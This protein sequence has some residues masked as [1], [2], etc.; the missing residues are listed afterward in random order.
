MKLIE[1]L[2]S[3]QIALISNGKFDDM[4]LILK[5]AFPRTEGANGAFKYYSI[6]KTIVGNFQGS[7][8]HPNIT[9][10]EAKNF[11]EEMK[12][13][14]PVESLP[15]RK[16]TSTQA[17]SIIDAACSAWKKTLADKW[18]IGIVLDNK[19][20]IE[21][22]FYQEMRKAC[23][24]EQN[25][26]FDIIFDD[27]PQ[28]EVGGYFTVVEEKYGYNGEK[29]KTYKIIRIKDCNLYYEENNSVGTNNVKVRPATQDEIDSV[30]YIA[31]GTPCLVSG[32]KKNWF[33]RYSDGKGQFYDGG[34]T[35]SVYKSRWAYVS[36][37]DASAIANLPK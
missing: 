36:P 28:Y 6:H 8:I 1:Q 35:N 5:T 26:L 18:A 32:E 27:K 19:I 22:T 33:L 7:D 20:E 10:I 24:R 23:T 34:E 37:V 29:G 31:R 11:L 12:Q 21:E 4:R 2:R 14:R 13:P 25:T 17:K 3:G 9:A 16:I 30:L 15:A